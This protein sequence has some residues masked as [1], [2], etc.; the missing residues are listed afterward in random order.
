MIPK[1]LWLL[2]VLKYNPIII[3]S[4]LKT[5]IHTYINLDFYTMRLP[6]YSEDV[7]LILVFELTL[8]IP[9]GLK[10]SKNPYFANKKK[11]YVM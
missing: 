7:K 10:S 1:A 5:I 2:E 11:A 4:L 6:A 3:N 8:N 9:E